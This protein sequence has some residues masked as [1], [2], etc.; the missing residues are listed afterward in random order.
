MP[1]EAKARSEKVIKEE[2]VDLVGRVTT[3]APVDTGNL[4][5]NVKFEEQGEQ[6]E[7]SSR[8]F[9]AQGQDYAPHVEYGTRFTKP[10]PYFWHNVRTAQQQIIAKL[11][12][13][14]NDISK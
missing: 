14:L 9:N 1:Q 11:Q 12:A 7:V 13:I 8:A 2:A 10:Q 3:E 4:R 6:V 5:R